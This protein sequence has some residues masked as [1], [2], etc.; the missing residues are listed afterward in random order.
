MVS[1]QT[2]N[3][4]RWITFE[5]P[6]NE[7]TRCFLR[8]EFLFDQ[9]AHHRRQASSWDARAA[10]HTL[11]DILSVMGR[12]D[13]KTDLIKDLCDQRATL[14]QL[15]DHPGVDGTQLDRILTEI[16]H[17]VA[18]LQATLTRYPAAVLRES[19][20]LGAVMNRFAI[21]GGTCSFDLPSYHRWLTRPHEAIIA[22]LDRWYG[23]LDA[24]EGGIR[25][26]LRLLRES[27][28]STEEEA[29]NGV[30]L[31]T[32]R[33]H[34][35]LIRVHI[36]AAMDVYPETSANHYRVSIRFM[37]LGDVDDRN[38]QVR[39]PIGFRLQCCAPTRS[40]AYA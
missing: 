13:F 10:L 23:H 22:D 2:G 28:A 36:P 20:L 27:T 7:R 3:A 11:L 8:L 14:V 32:P 15:S 17:A 16:D 26:Y 4:P 25:V 24:L 40:P 35:H 1:D 39:G 9:Y 21:P 5:Q 34:Y 38:S 18:R 19:D 29:N 30:F 6:L 12:N 37:H 33:A 31:Y